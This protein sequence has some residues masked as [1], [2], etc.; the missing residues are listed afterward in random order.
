MIPAATVIHA[1][2]PHSCDGCQ[3]LAEASQAGPGS[4]PVIRYVWSRSWCRLHVTPFARCALYEKPPAG[5]P[6][7][8]SSLMTR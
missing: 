6:S 7:N 4:A 2:P 5:K 8:L 1:E 3:H